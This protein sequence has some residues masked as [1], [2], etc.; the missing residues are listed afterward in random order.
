MSADFLE[1]TIDKFLLQVR[2]DLRYSNDDL[3]VK[4]ENGHCS[5]GLTDYAQRKDGDII[6]LEFLSAENT[7]EEGSPIASYE[8]IKAA[9]DVKSPFDCEIIDLNHDLEERPELIHEDPYGAGWIAR[10]KPLNPEG[11]EDLLSPQEY[12]EFMKKRAE[13]SSVKG[14]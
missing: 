9:L 10:L 5:L 2:K 14:D 3:W 4:E 12:F 11:V 7:I 1:T 13:S 6:F 8:T